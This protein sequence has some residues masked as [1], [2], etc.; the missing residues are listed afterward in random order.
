MERFFAELDK[1]NAAT[2]P[3]T[4]HHI[5]EHFWDA[6]GAHKAPLVLDMSGFSALTT[7]YGIMHYLAMVRRMQLA[8]RPMV[9]RT[10]GQIVKFE[11]DNL[12]AVYDEVE[13]AIRAAI[14]MNLSLEAM[15]T[16]TDD[17]RDIH[18]SIGIAYG[19]LLLVPEQ[20]FYGDPVN[21]ASKLGE[22]IAG[23]GEILVTEAAFERVRPDS[24]I[25]TEKLEMSI[26]GITIAA[27]KVRY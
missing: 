10:G 7:R 6:F 20:D 22:D 26:S 13:P 17:T 21:L 3:D 16:M 9:E 1:Y 23:R 27:H 15:N 2:Q 18:V 8:L 25:Q 12:F 14:Q 5:E 19:K 24:G 4:R 11:A